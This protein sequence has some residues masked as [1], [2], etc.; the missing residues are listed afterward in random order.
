MY[1]VYIL[2]AVEGNEEKMAKR[3]FSVR[4]V[5]V[6]FFALLVIVSAAY[7][8]VS[9]H[10]TPKAHATGTSHWLYVVEDGT[11]YIYDIDNN[12]ALVRTFPIPETGKRGVAVSPSRGMLYVSYCGATV[13]AGSHGNLLAYDLVNNSVAWNVSYSF[14]VD[15]PAVTPDGSKIYMPHGSDASDG[16]TSIIDA[17]N[18]NVIGSINTGTNGHN[19]VAS[20]DGTQVYITGYSG[21][22]YNYIHVVNPATDAVVSNIGPTINGVRPFTVNGK[23]TMIFTTSSNTCGFQVFNLT[24]GASL[25]TIPFS[26][27]CA[28]SVSTAPS[29]G[30]SLSPD[31]R[32]VYVMDA[33]LDQL[34]VYDVSGLPA[35]APT[36]VASVQLSSLSGYSSPCQTFCE[37]EGW[38]L[39]DLS[40]RYVYVGDSGDVVDTSTLRSIQTLPAL[41]NTRQMIEID[42]TNGAISATS[43][44]FGVGHVTT[45][46]IPSPTPT[47]TTPAGP[48]N[49]NWYFAE[50]RVGKGFR[51][52]LSIENPSSTSCTATVYYS[53]IPDGGRAATRIVA[54]TVHPYSRWTEAV[55]QD[56]SYTESSNTGANV[57]AIVTVDTMVTPNCNGVV[58]ERPMYFRNYHGISSGTDVLGSTTANT[59]YYFADVPSS[60]TVLSYLTLLN[61]GNTNANVTATYY[62]NGGVVGTQTATVGASA[63]GTIAPGAITL[64]AHVAAVVTS[65]QPIVVERPTYLVNTPVNGAYDIV[66]VSNLAHDWLFAEG[67]TTNA[68]QEYLT[69]ANLDSANTAATVNITLK[70]KTGVTSTYT[71]TV[72]AWSQTIWNVNANNGFAGSSPEVSA[73][74]T[75]TGASIVVQREMYF[76]YKHTL[77][78]GRAMTS[79]GATDVVGQVG[80]ATHTAYS[81]AEG[82]ANMGYNDWLTIQNPTNASETISVTMF[83]GNGQSYTQNE[84]VPANARFTL[85]TASI[86]QGA[87]FHAGSSTDA[88]SF[89]MTV[90]TTNSGVFVAERPVYFNTSGSSFPVQGGDDIIGYV[91][92]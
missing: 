70:S 90:Q 86:I 84:T 52:Y 51:E 7:G 30:I 16:I 53:Y 5:L 77:T 56:L 9:T 3:I 75:A 6:A 49:R 44:R 64:P 34:E 63:R 17:S 26:G 59:S 35:T 22:N 8:L 1:G 40:G 4:Y 39:N 71:V 24:T 66:G 57:A 67:Y 11:V 36:F 83:N 60:P 37:R 33:P 50:G 21:T 15:Q 27:S 10:T 43:T 54:V 41:Q 23:H 87:P 89:S 69:I 12:H 48:V 38:V 47:T 76:T 31:E 81:F 74:V 46:S 25:Y 18:G 65:S 85:D 58:A 82:Y 79:I 80:P 28:W 42:W 19:V 45:T 73:E 92:G 29:H 14:G 55:N 61:P 88:N 20:L 13:C 32:R 2:D 72:N 78:N 91:G 62:L 68:S